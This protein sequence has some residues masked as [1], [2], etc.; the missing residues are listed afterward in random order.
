MVETID[1]EKGNRFPNDPDRVA[2][3]QRWLQAIKDRTIKAGV[4]DPYLLTEAVLRADTGI[5]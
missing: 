5:P 2:C 3:R 1:N 4:L